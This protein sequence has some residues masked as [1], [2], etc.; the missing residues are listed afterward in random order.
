MIRLSIVSTLYRSE[1]QLDEFYR[2]VVAA[3]EQ[4]TP[5]FELVLVDDGS[6]DESV[7]IARGLMAHDHR[8]RLVRLSRNYGHFHAIMT[9]L[10][11]AR[12]ELIFLVD[13]D[14]EESPEALRA[15]FDRMQ[16][17]SADDPIDV[18]Y[19]VQRRRKGHL[20]ERS[21]GAL[22]YWLFNHLSDVK[23]PRNALVARLMTRR[24]VNAL[25]RHRERELFMLGVMT[26]VGFR[27][28]PVLVEKSDTAPTTYT[29]LKK[30]S[31]T[32]KSMASFSDKPLSAIFLLGLGISF[33]AVLGML[34]LVITY[35]AFSWHY[36][37]G[38]T[39]LSLLVSF[40]G[41]MILISIGTVG[42]YL[43]RVFVE[44]KDRPVIVMQ[45]EGSVAADTGGTRELAGHAGS[46]RAIGSAGAPDDH[47]GIVRRFLRVLERKVEVRGVIHVGAH[48]GQEVDP[49]LAHGCGRIVLVEPNPDACRI[50]RERFG[51]RPEVQVIE[52]AALDEA[53]SATLRLHTSRSG[54]TE[55]ASVLELKRF[56]EI[57][58]TL[59]TPRTVE[60]NA[61]RLDML[62]ERSGI[63]GADFQ[64][65]NVDVQGAELR[66]LRGAERTLASVAA[67]LAEVHVVDLYDGAATE[68]ELD[69][70]LRARGFERADVV[71]HDL[72][73]EN[74]TFPAW[75]EAL[76]VRSH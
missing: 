18:V 53:G 28:E 4:L 24:Y 13:S 26:Q 47:A 35:V 62:L 20:L 57:V 11:H 55:P 22:F 31:L 15:F 33:V 6:P 67:V 72:Y 1:D 65:L 69:E 27:Q 60:V 75:G 38:W 46:P 23:V 39:S 74:G 49:Y 45:V 19:G 30:I 5:D 68:R 41:G 3:A 21:L 25:L 61:D 2:R 10:D 12:G 43:G 56:K 32:L 54:S 51:S 73:D 58:P 7:R 9:G 8:I 48:E 34:Y 37:V 50:L 29:L 66:V 17:A 59:E 64:L 52:A 14:L 63:D 16:Q 76:Y 36:L 44:V 40:F 42:F 71:Y 70:F